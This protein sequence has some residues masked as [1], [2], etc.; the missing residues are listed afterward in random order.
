MYTKISFFAPSATGICVKHNAF[1]YAPQANFAKL[2]LIATF[3]GSAPFWMRVVS[4]TQN[5]CWEN[6]WGPRMCYQ[7]A[8][9][10]YLFGCFAETPVDVKN[11]CVKWRRSVC[12]FRLQLPLFHATFC[13]ALHVLSH[14][15]PAA[16]KFHDD[17]ERWEGNFA[18]GFAS[19]DLRHSRWLNCANQRNIFG[20]TDVQTQ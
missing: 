15:E 8:P 19:V 11:D 2:I 18:H 9:A 10:A 7:R 1:F 5:N 3:D 16:S 6:L 4:A 13:Q 20:L 12:C 17:E 14:Y